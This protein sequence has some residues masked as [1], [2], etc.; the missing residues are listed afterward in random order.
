[1]L[2]PPQQLEQSDQ[3]VDEDRQE[4]G[5]SER[6]QQAT[7]RTSV[8]A[9]AA[10]ADAPLAERTLCLHMLRIHLEG[11]VQT[12]NY[13][14]G[15]AL[16]LGYPRRITVARS[17]ATSVAKWTLEELRNALRFDRLLRT[18]RTRDNTFRFSWPGYGG[19]YERN[20]GYRAHISR[21][22]PHDGRVDE[23]RVEDR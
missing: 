17:T 18:R 16:I 4:H 14:S 19:L 3:D 2:Q 1:M 10:F 8:D 5:R 9:Y 20:G 7:G 15:L 12:R 13:P 11:D 6:K 21:K 22:G 23:D